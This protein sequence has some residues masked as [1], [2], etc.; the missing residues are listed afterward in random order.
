MSSNVTDN[1]TLVVSYSYVPFYR[2]ALFMVE[3][4]LAFILNSMF[5]FVLARN[6]DLVKSKRITYHVA[7]LALTDTLVG[8]SLFFTATIRSGIVHVNIDCF[9]WFYSIKLGALFVSVMAV[10]FMAIERIVV[11]KRPYTWK[12]ILTLKRVFVV[13][14]ITWITAVILVIIPLTIGSKLSK[15]ILFLIIFSF[16][17]IAILIANSVIIYLLQYRKKRRLVA[18]AGT[19]Q[20][21]NRSKEKALKLV[22]MQNIILAVTCGPFT[23]LHLTLYLCTSFSR[24]NCNL[25]IVFLYHDVLPYFHILIYTNF[26]VNPIIYIWRDNTY[27]KAFCSMFKKIRNAT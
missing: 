19:Q 5:L 4:V 2:E 6:K 10:L 7:N 25:N 20:T 3:G 8:F 11:I 18:I 16:S 12:E 23:V 21:T 27:R 1:N 9:V 13:I 22:V 14:F 15:S 26:L 17:G 24:S